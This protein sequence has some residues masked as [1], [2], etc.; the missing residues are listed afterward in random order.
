MSAEEKKRIKVA[1][2]DDH[3]MIIEG[4]VNVLQECDRIDVIDTYTSAG[5][6]LNGLQ[7]NVPDVLLLDAQL[8]DQQAHEIVGVLSEKW[9][10]LAI[11]IL[12]G[13]DSRYYIKEMIRQ[14]CS[15]YLLKSNTDRNLLITA[16]EEVYEGNTFLDPSIREVILKDM[17]HGQK[18]GALLPRI[19]TREKE[20]LQLIAQE[21]DNQEIAEKL[22]I[23]TRTVENH[24]YN[25]LQKLDVKNTVGLIKV[26]LQMGMLK[27]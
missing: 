6:L 18:K 24:R 9:P 12:S 19:T 23:S 11:L 4:L 16:I 3:Q 2:T 17:L 27:S 22:F 7:K 20:I 13:L 1:V 26:A 8:P 14:G 10:K 25:L 5:A 15:G 21:Y